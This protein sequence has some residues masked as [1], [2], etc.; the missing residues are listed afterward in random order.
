MAR[1]HSCNVLQIRPESVQLWRFAANNGDV[2][3]TF[4]QTGM[5]ADQLPARM[6]GKDWRALWQRKLNLAWVPAHQ[7][8]LR[9]VHLPTSDPKELQ[10]M[11]ELQLERLSPLP[12]AQIV[13]SYEVLPRTSGNSQTVIVTIVA[14]NVV[15]T[16]L[17]EL[18]GYGYL[19]DRLELPFLH[20]L[21]TTEIDGD[22]CW[23]YPSSGPGTSYCAV[24]WWY[25]GLLQNL[26]LIHLP[27]TDDWPSVLGQELTKLAWAG[28]IE[29]WL[30]STPRYRLVADAATATVWEPVLRRLI[31][32]PVDV[33]PSLR[34]PELAALNARRVARS[35]SRANLLPPEHAARYQQQFIDR[36]WMRGLGALVALYVAG[37]MVYFAALE[38]IKFQ[39]HRVEQQIAKISGSHTNALQLKARGQ[40]LQEQFDLK[41]AALDCWKAIT[42]NLPQELTLQS[43]AFNQ[44]GLVNLNGIATE[45]SKVLDYMADLGKVVVRDKPLFSKVSPQ[46]IR[47]GPGVLGPQTISWRIE[48]DRQ[49]WEVR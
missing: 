32:E 15:E 36:L 1:I 8:F 34:P 4:E 25:G 7:V 14:R 28:E 38:V 13:W 47:T 49:R 19:A 31:D 5:P 29:G 39:T 45:Q 42:E 12:V 40:V 22:G 6:I 3:L 11:V 44:A 20:Q 48:C 26:S 2:Y 18:E 41:Y 46:S 21:L 24:A 33:I 30:T 17:G 10:S 27:P 23:L 35:E 16:F 9:V 43:I 37:V